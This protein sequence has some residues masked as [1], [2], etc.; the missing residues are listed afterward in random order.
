MPVIVVG[1]DTQRSQDLVKRLVE[2][3]GEVRVFIS[4][5]EKLEEMRFLGAK[6][7][8]G[9]LS[10]TSHLEGAATGAFCAVVLVEAAADGRELA[11]S[12]PEK[13]PGEWLEALRAAGITRLILVG[14]D[15][16]APAGFPEMRIVGSKGRDPDAILEEILVLEEAGSV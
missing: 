2:K 9:D 12:T 8:L 1:A 14:D 3:G 11:F 7:A 15:Q 10:D 6:V 16:S 4:D 13:L 5:P